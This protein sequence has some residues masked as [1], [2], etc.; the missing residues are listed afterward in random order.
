[1]QE[2][3]EVQGWHPASWTHSPP[4]T[5]LASVCCPAEIRDKDD[6]RAVVL[7]SFNV[8]VSVH[9]QYKYN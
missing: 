2:E 1:M 9:H 4:A 8:R 5:D 7:N 3:Q 6:K